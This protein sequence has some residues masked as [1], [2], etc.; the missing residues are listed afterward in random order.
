MQHERFGRDRFE[1]IITEGERKLSGESGVFVHGDDEV[2]A[3][4]GSGILYDHVSN[5]R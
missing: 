1:A 2:L 4:S 3:G 5:P